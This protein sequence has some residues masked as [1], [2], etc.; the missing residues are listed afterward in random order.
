MAGSPQDCAEIINRCQEE[1][2]LDYVGL[3]S[4]NLPSEFSARLD[5]L[6]IISEELL[7]RLQ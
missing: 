5:Y 7:P 3:A 1:D 2:G 4:L 6:Q